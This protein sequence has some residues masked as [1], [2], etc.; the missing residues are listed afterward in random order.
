MEDY[1]RSAVITGGSSG[2]GA[3]FARLLPEQTHL[4]LTGRDTIALSTLYAELARPGR[5]IE[6]LSAD[7]STQLGRTTVIEAA[8]RVQVD[9]FISN[10]GLGTA[11]HFEMSLS[12]AERQT[13]EVNVIAT[14]ELLHALI[15]S[16]IATAK[17]NGRRSGIIVVTSN[18]AFGPC[19]N[20]AV[21]G[22]TKAFQMRLV[23]TLAVELKDEPI[24][25]LALCPTYTNTNFFRRA[26]APQPEWMVSPMVPAR[27]ALDL[28]GRKTVHSCSGEALSGRLWRQPLRSARRL[29]GTAVHAAFAELRQGVK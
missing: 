24:D 9:L 10:A 17:R 26:G 23:E 14:T 2:I 8:E 13:I 25:L 11:G 5:L 21:Y 3:A 16:M 20:F 22:A 7:L 15:P 1:F 12:V 4:L 18:A 29:V 6:T 28:L 19:E 27:E